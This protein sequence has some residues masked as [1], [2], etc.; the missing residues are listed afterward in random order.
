M[1]A[2]VVRASLRAPIL[3]LIAGALLLAYGIMTVAT[4]R[5]DVFPEFVPPQ[6]TVQT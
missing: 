2:T 4:A 1:L 3:V 6:A 5:Y